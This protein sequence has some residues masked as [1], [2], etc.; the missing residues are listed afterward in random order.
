MMLLRYKYLQSIKSQCLVI[1]IN[2]IAKDIKFIF[3]GK[4]AIKR[5]LNGVLKDRGTAAGEINVIFLSDAAILSL[6]RSSLGHNYYTD[7]ITFDYSQD[8]P[9]GKIYAD[10]YISVETVLANSKT[11]K[12]L[13]VNKFESELCRVMVHGILHLTGEDDLTP[14]QQKKMRSAENF[15]LSRIAEEIDNCS[16]KC[17]L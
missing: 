2:F 9:D 5:W 6:N 14:T 4:N 15:Y 16:I 12:Q 8:M 7:I 10:L 3:T 13:S 11:Y 17:N 1:M